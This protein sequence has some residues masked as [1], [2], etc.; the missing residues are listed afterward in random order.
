LTLSSRGRIT[1]VL[2]HGFNPHASL[3]VTMYFTLWVII[4]QW[5]NSWLHVTTQVT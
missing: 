4:E 2:S 3:R 5:T 1:T